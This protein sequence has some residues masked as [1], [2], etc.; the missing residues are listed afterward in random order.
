MALG[1]LLGVLPGLHAA[2]AP[3]EE[4]A[5]K[6]PSGQVIESVRALEN[7]AQ[8][9]ALYLPSSY[10]P[11]R[12]WPLLMAFDPFAEGVTPVKLFADAAEKYGYIVVGSNNSKNGPSGPEVEAFNALWREVHARFRVDDG[13]VY[14]TGLSGAARFSS[15]V[16]SSCRCL[17]GVILSGA[18][19]PPDH[20]PAAGMKFA[21]YVAVGEYDFNFPELIQLRQELERDQVAHH[22]NIFDGGH[23]WMPPAVAQAAI[24]WLNLQAMVRGTLLRDDAFIAAQWAERLQQ[25]QTEERKHDAYAAFYSY[26]SLAADFGSLRDVSEARAA[27][28]R[29]RGSPEFHRAQAR[30]DDEI[31]KQS[32]I[33]APIIARMRM[34]ASNPNAEIASP[35][36][37]QQPPAMGGGMTSGGMMGGG[38]MGRSS[39]GAGPEQNSGGPSQSVRQWLEGELTSLRQQRERERNPEKLTVLRRALGEVF[40]ETSESGSTMVEARNYRAAAG[41][42][43]LATFAA[44]KASAELHY[45]AAA[46]YCLDGDKKQSLR[47]LRQA[48]AEGFHDG[49]RLEQDKDFDALRGSPEFQAVVGKL[50][51][52]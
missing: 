31:R 7:P 45:Q 27:A 37:I 44:P 26:S 22:L 15:A 16:A 40:V 1:F 9:Y 5:A 13:R 51:A 41:Y 33:T 14:A 17:A 50:P 20:P 32:S 29:L 6:L 35:A 34:L 48:V 30:I 23:Q 18:G 8:S 4:P 42:F 3:P 24:A 39:V 25:A 46:A 28:E 21:V 11:D 38:G 43:E 10:T 2:A 47:V 12:T 49:A 52:K 36:P 19:F